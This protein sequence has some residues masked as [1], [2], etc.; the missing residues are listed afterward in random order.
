MFR[1]KGRASAK[2][3]EKDFPY[4]VE[5]RVPLDGFGKKLDAMYEW[6]TRH[7]LKPMT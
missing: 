6:F 5:K 3:I 2:P 4:I 1:Y 7:G